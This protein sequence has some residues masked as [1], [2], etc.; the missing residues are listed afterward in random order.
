VFGEAH[1]VRVPHRFIEGGYLPPDFVRDLRPTADP[2]DD[3]EE[4]AYVVPAGAP[5]W[6][7]GEGPPARTL[8][9]RAGAELYIVDV[10][11]IQGAFRVEVST[12]GLFLQADGGMLLKGVASVTARGYLELTSK[13]LIVA[14]SLDLDTPSLRAIGIDFD[15]NAELVLNT[16]SEDRTIYPLS[17]RLLLEPIVV[18]AGDFDIKAEGLLAFRIPAPTSN[19]PAFPAYSRWIRKPNATR[20]LRLASCRSGLAVCGCSRCRSLSVFASSMRASRRIWWSPPPAA[21]RQSPSWK[22]LSGWC[23][24]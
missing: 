2:D 8:S 20:F 18:K 7:G 23:P 21:Y 1:E 12:E 17:D 13:G 6:G 11:V 15:V 19:S 16:T 24:T 5:K 3:P 22:A 14:M 10:F 4:L 9:C